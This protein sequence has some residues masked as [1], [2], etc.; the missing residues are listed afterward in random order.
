MQSDLP[1][2]NDALLRCA[3]L[4]KR[5]VQGGWL[6]KNRR[7]VQALKD[8]SLSV[9]AGSTLALIGE[10]GSGKSTLAR[11][12][13]CLEKPDSGELWFAGRNVATLT[14]RERVAFQ[15]QIQIVFQE[16]AASLNPR[17]N[18][19][20][21]VSEPLLIAG[22]S[23]KQRHHRALYLMRLVGLPDD[24]AK[25]LPSEFSGGQRR[26]LAIA[27][28]LALEPSILILDESL[29]GLDPSIQAQISNLLTE[30]QGTYHLTYVHISHDLDLVAHLADEIAVLHQGQI[31]EI[32]PASI[33]LAD[34]HDKF[35][36][37]L[38]K[39]ARVSSFGAGLP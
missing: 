20:E 5:Y 30:L 11:C 16:P 10:S 3:H 2:P 33:G 23:K 29:S 17:L 19:I 25:R 18:A 21:I 15:R 4:S 31:V 35:M 22:E 26:R 8:V 38:Q 1:R 37:R 14:H 34:L 12:L 24:S 6:S 39:A 13:T 32:V 36:G 7:E 27:R 9:R 28:A